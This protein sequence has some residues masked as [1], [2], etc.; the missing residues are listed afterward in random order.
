MASLGV[1]LRGRGACGHRVPTRAVVRPGCA[2][3]RVEVGWTGSHPR[4]APPGRRAWDLTR[5]LAFVASARM[6]HPAVVRSRC[7]AGT[8]H[9]GA[10]ERRQLLLFALTGAPWVSPADCF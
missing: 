1:R 3:A 10:S 6:G 2:E 8:R 7:Q 4:R 9:H 5:L